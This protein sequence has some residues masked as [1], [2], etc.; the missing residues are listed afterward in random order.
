MSNF[1]V[2]R[3]IGN[4]LS[5][6]TAGKKLFVELGDGRTVWARRWS[7]LT[8]MHAADLG[9][10][11]L[12][13]EAQLSICKR[14]AAIECQLESLEAKMSASAPVDLGV[15]ARLT[16]VLCRLFEL[17]G[18]RRLTK[19]IDPTSALAKALE[20]YPATAIDDAGDEDDSDEPPPA[21]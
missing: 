13:S 6:V 19:P 3:G 7:D 1:R 8:L 16:G 21:Q 4:H 12:L 18:I 2:R 15:Y 20:A 10:R 17:V 5:L 9:G 14:A 11:D